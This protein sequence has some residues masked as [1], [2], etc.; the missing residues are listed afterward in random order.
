VFEQ[1]DEYGVVRKIES[2]DYL[3]RVSDLSTKPKRGDLI[4]E[5][6]GTST[7]S[8]E[9]V[10]PTSGGEPEFRYSDPYRKAYRIRTK[11]VATA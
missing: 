5:T 1:T 4:T 7:F 2:R 6:E 10:S 9:V 3:I 8:Y 11:L